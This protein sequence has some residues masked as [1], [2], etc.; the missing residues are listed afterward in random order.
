MCKNIM[1]S[2]T[3][4]MTIIEQ[5]KKLKYEQNFVISYENMRR[6]SGLLKQGYGGMK[7]TVMTHVHVFKTCLN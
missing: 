6:K 4:K 7:P 1:E 5:K 3:F 2:S